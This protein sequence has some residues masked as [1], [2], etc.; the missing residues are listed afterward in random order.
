MLVVS[1]TTDAESS[2]PPL[3]FSA[4]TNALSAPPFQ[5]SPTSLSPTL[6]VYCPGS[7]V[8]SIGRERERKRSAVATCF[9]RI[10]FVSSVA[11]RVAVA[12]SE[13]SSD[14]AATLSLKGFWKP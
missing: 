4:S 7:T 5:D 13:D 1:F 14:D 3:A 8:K 9:T 2:E 11:W 12:T 10:C 6:N